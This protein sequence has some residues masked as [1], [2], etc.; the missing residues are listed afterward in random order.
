M[1]LTSYP[2]D[3]TRLGDVLVTG[4]PYQFLDGHSQRRDPNTG[5]P[6]WTVRASLLDVDLTDFAGEVSLRLPSA[7]QPTV[8]P[9]DF[10]LLTG[11]ARVS[12]Y[13]TGR[14]ADARASVSLRGEGFDVVEVSDV[15]ASGDASRGLFVAWDGSS[16]LRFTRAAT[17]GYRPGRPDGACFHYEVARPYESDAGAG[18]ERHVVEVRGDL[19][20]I[21]RMAVV[22]FDG[23]RV[24]PTLNRETR[25]AGLQLVADAVRTVDTPT[26]APTGRSRRPEPTPEPA[27][28]EG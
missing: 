10:I 20:P 1:A 26:P 9:S 23:L 24:I 22:D 14:G 13:Q 18:V 25:R 12:S 4:A 7:D 8:R 17:A 6:L 11:A 28:A 5:L 3:P 16:E 21:R 27:A 19:A 15:D 2:I